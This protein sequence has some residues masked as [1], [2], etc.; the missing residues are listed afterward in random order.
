MPS[1]AVPARSSP[2]FGA[3]PSLS[4]VPAAVAL[5]G[6]PG[7]PGRVDPG[8]HA[9]AAAVDL[10][11]AQIDQCQQARGRRPRPGWREQRAV[12]R[13]FLATAR[14][15]DFDAL[16][17]LLDPEVRL[18]AGTPAGTVVVFG[19]T[20]VAAA[21]ARLSAAAATRRREV[22]VNGLPGM[23]SWRTDGARLSVHAFTVVGGRITRITALTDPAGLALMDLPDPGRA[24]GTDRAAYGDARGQVRHDRPR[25]T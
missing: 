3:P 1:P 20:E 10:A 11:G 13:A 23:V 4:A 25:R 17:R 2:S 15:G 9:G 16:L 24:A 22:L 12:V 18:T 19:A 5:P 8:A 21:G 7:L 6:L 14:H